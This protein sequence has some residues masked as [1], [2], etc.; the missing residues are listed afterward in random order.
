MP[1]IREGAVRRGTFLDA[2]AELPTGVTVVTARRADGA[3][4]GATVSVFSSLSLRPRLVVVCLAHSSET[5]QALEHGDSFL[6]HVLRDGQEHVARALAGKGPDKFDGIA[7]QTSPEGL[8]EIPDCAVTLACDVDGLLPGGD[9]AIVVGAVRRVAFGGGT[10]L[11]YHRRR[12]HTA[13][14]HAAHV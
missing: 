11:V 1:R 6:V 10:P 3:P 14:E 4:L 8:P 12:L 2:M 5:R 7:W 9:H 13:P